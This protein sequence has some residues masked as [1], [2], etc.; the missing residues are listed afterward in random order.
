MSKKKDPRVVRTMSFDQFD[1]LT[2][3][4]YDFRNS[5]DDMQCDTSTM[6]IDFYDNGEIKVGAQFTGYT[7]QDITV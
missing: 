3:N 1:K 7:D 2:E 4:V 5:G 6:H